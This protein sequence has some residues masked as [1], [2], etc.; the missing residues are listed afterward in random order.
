MLIASCQSMCS[1]CCRCSTIIMKRMKQAALFGFLVLNMLI[2]LCL[3][4]LSDWFASH[5]ILRLQ[6]WFV[7]VNQRVCS[8]KGDCTPKGGW[9][10]TQFTPPGS[11]PVL[12]SP[13]EGRAALQEEP[14]N[15][16]NWSAVL[17]TEGHLHV[18][19]N[20]VTRRC[21]FRAGLRF[22]KYLWWSRATQVRA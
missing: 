17:L 10:A 12:V 3:P 2:I 13:C 22:V 6:E 14:G 20:H 1:C 19:I 21:M 5:H 11:A 7:Q 15:K 18:H 4:C 16:A 9:L 8:N